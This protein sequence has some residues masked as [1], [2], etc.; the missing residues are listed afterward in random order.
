KG[1]DKGEISLSVKIARQGN[2]ILE[3]DKISKSFNGKK[4]I[5]DFSYVFKKGDRIGLAG[6]NGTGKSTFLN[7]ITQEYLPDAGK[8][9]VGETTVYGYYR[10]NGLPLE[11][12]ERVIDVVKNVAEYI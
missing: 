5:Q 9:D 1:T 7:L 10:Q 3:L 6:K 11:A 12:G 2:K 4:I 8:V